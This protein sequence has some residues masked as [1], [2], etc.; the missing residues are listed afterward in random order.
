MKRFILIVVCLL[1]QNLYCQDLIF[2]NFFNSAIYS[3]PAFTG[4]NFDSFTNNS[5]RI[6]S[7]FR[8]QWLPNN[9]NVF[10]SNFLSYDQAIKTTNGSLGGYFISDRFG[11][12]G[13]YNSTQA[14]IAYSY[15]TPFNK[16]GLIGRYGL[17]VGI[18]NQNVDFGKLRFEDQIDY[19]TDV[20]S[21]TNEVIKG[22]SLSR[23]DV[24]AGVV[25]YNKKSFLSF[26]MHNI[27][28]PN[29]DYIGMTDNYIKRRIHIQMGKKFYIGNNNKSITS[30][31]S[32]YKQGLFTQSSCNIVCNLNL[33]SIGSGIKNV[34]L[35]RN[36]AIINSTFI[37]LNQKRYSI[38]YLYES[39]F[40]SKQIFSSPTHEISMRF[41][42]YN[43]TR[44]PINSGFM[45]SY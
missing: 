31:L 36:K 35:E 41:N 14:N 29:F 10:Q 30:I 6:Q 2:G 8:T 39:N 33:I 26:S 7:T 20:L 19:R 32:Y 25:L 37:S 16:D 43:T 28:K 17:S 40:W 21:S 11:V 44:H 18:K 13:F 5:S 27:T 34:G 9:P 23:V 42:V 3:N 12:N 4:A 38:Q 1:N 24:N 22:N 45:M 15:F